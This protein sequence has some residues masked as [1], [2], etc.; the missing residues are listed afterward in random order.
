MYPDS[1]VHGANMGP[2]WVLSA[3][4]WPHVGPVNLATCEVSLAQLMVGVTSI[5]IMRRPICVTCTSKERL[6]WFLNRGEG[7]IHFIRVRV[8]SVFSDK[9]L[10]SCL[11]DIQCSQT[12]VFRRI[13][14]LVLFLLASQRHFSMIIR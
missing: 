6:P 14:E 9:F 11:R 1:K 2:T 7:V 8:L 4:Y 13:S 5:F 3:P 10:H 12:I